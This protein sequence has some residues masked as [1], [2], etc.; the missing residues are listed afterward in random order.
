M[1]KNPP[2]QRNWNQTTML[3]KERTRLKIQKRN[4]KLRRMMTK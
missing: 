2:K 3:Q 1:Q 4:R